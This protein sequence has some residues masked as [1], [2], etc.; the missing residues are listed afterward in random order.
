MKT[1]ETQLLPCDHDLASVTVVRVENG[2]R[3]RCTVCGAESSERE[4][5]EWF[6]EAL[7]DEADEVGNGS[8]I[9]ATG[10]L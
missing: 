4:C 6:L 3:F 10:T 8:E 1:P 5:H 2:C 7:S 9:Q